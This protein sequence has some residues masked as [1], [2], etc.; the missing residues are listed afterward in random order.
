[1]PDLVVKDPIL[2]LHAHHE[3]VL[4]KRLSP[5]AV[6]LI[7]TGNLL[8]NSLYIG[9]QKPLEVK[10]DPFIF[11]ESG[12]LVELRIVQDRSTLRQCFK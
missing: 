1:M 5:A 9:R 10:L 11:A 2:L 12:A 8:L 3:R 7:C 6:L 4:G